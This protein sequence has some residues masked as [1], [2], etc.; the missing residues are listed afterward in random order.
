MRHAPFDPAAR[1]RRLA[2][3]GGLGGSYAAGL[4]WGVL[5]CSM[6]YLALFY[7]MLAGSGP[8]GAQV[9]AGFGLG[10]VP[11]VVATAFGVTQL[12]RLTASKRVRAS[13]GVAL[14]GVAVASALLPAAAWQTL[15][16]T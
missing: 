11:A 4:A 12:R 2:M 1:A 14:I 13:A 7:A 10:T 8:G 3:A 5:P 9:M 15:C 6:V 16:I